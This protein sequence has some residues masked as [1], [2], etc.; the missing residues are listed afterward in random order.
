MGDIG[1]HFASFAVILFQRVGHFVEAVAQIAENI[2][3]LCLP[4]TCL[5]VAAGN[6]LRRGY[7][8]RQWSY[9]PARKQQADQ[10]R[11]YGQEKGQTE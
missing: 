5:Q 1:Q 9:H 6:L 2:L 8:F 11:E 7:D 3:V 10:G 4:D